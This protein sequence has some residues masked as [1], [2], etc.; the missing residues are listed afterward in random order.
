LI[1]DS[2]IAPVPGFGC[3]L[4]CLGMATCLD[5]GYIWYRLYQVIFLYVVVSWHSAEE[6]RQLILSLM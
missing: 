2:A 4:A 6:F 5:R 1:A 3:T